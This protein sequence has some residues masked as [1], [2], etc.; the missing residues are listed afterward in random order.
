[1]DAEGGASEALGRILRKQ[2]KPIPL[3][4]VQDQHPHHPTADYNGQELQLLVQWR[5][6]LCRMHKGHHH[7]CGA[8]AHSR[9]NEEDLTEDEYFKAATLKS[10][11]DIRKHVTSTKV[12]LPTSLQGVVRALNNYCRLLDVLFGPDCPHLAH[13]ISIQDGL[14]THE[15]ELESRLTGV[16]ILHLMWRVHHDA[17]QFFLACER[18][19]DGEQ[20]PHSTLGN[21]VRQLVDD[22]SIQVTITCPEAMFLGTPSRLPPDRSQRSIQ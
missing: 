2:L 22:C 3:S 11:A 10:V 19:E 12:E 15:A 20:L 6:D 14:E 7:L 1:M 18:W 8:V 4:P 21:T 13:V 17:R 9:G 5:Q 16:L